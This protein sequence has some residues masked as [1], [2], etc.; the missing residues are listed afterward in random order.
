[1]FSDA[2]FTRTRPRS[3]CSYRGGWKKEHLAKEKKDDL[4]L[5]A[6][7]IE[8]KKKKNYI[9]AILPSFLPSV[10]PSWE[11]CGAEE[12]MAVGKKTKNVSLREKLPLIHFK[13]CLRL[14]HT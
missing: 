13:K 5:G 6:R 8:A 7:H 10:R 11:D 9:R 4:T 1:M 3:H 12:P 2:L 14:A